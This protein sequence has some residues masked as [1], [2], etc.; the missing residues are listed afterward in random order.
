MKRTT[1]GMALAL[2]CLTTAARAEPTLELYIRDAQE[3][4]QGDPV[5]TA[6]DGYGNLELGF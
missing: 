5:S 1:S 4:F 2:L 6:V 3:V